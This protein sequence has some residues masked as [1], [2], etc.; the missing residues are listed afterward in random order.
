MGLS[1]QD[2]HRPR[3]GL[4]LPAVRGQGYLGAFTK[5]AMTL[6]ALA[7]L[8]LFPVV[9]PLL[10]IHLPG[11]T[12]TWRCI[13]GNFHEVELHV[14]RECSGNAMQ[15]QTI[16][17][18][19]D[20][21]VAFNVSGLEPVEVL[22]VSQVCT[23][24]LGTTNCNGGGVAGIERYI[25]RTTVFLSPCNAWTFSW[26]ICCRNNSLNIEPSQGLHLEARL[27]N[28]AQ[29]CDASPTFAH[30]GVPLVC[31][32]QPVNYD[33]GAI[34]PDGH[35]LRF[36]LVDA[37][38][39]NPVVAPV[40]YSNGFT[41]AQPYTGMSIDTLTGRLSFTP[42]LQGYV[43]VSMLVEEFRADG[44]FIGS[45]VR[46]FPFIVQACTNTV[47]SANAGGFQSVT[48]ATVLG[49]YELE[50]CAGTSVC[51]ELNYTD[52]DAN[53]VLQQF[54]TIAAAL[55]GVEI[56][57]LDTSPLTLGLCWQVPANAS[58]I[59]RFTTLV[60]DDACPYRG[61][62]TF[63]Y[64][65]RIAQ[66]PNAGGDGQASYC[67]LAEPFAL[68]DSLTGTPTPFGQW[69]GPDGEST[70]IFVPGIGT[71]G[72]YTYMV[73]NSAGCSDSAV[74]VV[75]PLPS[76]DPLCILL[77]TSPAH[78][79]AFRA[80]PNPTSGTLQIE[81]AQG[82]RHVELMDA[83]GR[84]TWLRA[85]NAESRMTVELPGQVAN[86]VYLL[87]MSNAFGER[88]TQRIAIQR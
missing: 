86:G 76:S 28:L 44:V 21:G 61:L 41:G 80:G 42:D 36:S 9:S 69:T 14:W 16:S 47:P 87:I 81:G 33:P 49:P 38:L 19:N 40:A 1:G 66:P 79:H 23:S 58:G 12:I 7:L 20:C 57:T 74:V 37:L 3:K 78:T 54:N 6:R 48:G 26:D 64:I 53:T 46:D 56:D 13:G 82:L 15:P 73:Q 63:S 71:P 30:N 83:Q 35:R 45:V 29:N 25:Y 32:G 55:P 67:T 34:D 24:E 50:A 27:N 5:T 52:A 70:G 4:N 62:Q 18:S 11:G 39:Y 60:L 2:G 75:D 88:T 85:L 8:V 68:S 84:I 43:V 31:V 77:G 51:C 59:R 17:F 10:A 72:T 22:N 65:I